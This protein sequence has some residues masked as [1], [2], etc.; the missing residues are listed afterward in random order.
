[1]SIQTIHQCCEIS[2]IVSHDGLVDQ[3][4]NLEDL[5]RKRI[6]PERLLPA[7]SLHGRW[8][9]SSGIEKPFACSRRALS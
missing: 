7:E 1:M 6:D 3:I 8:M 5:H 9:L 2:D 4:A